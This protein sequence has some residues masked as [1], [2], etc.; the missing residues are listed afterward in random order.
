M[1]TRLAGIFV[2]VG[3]VAALA[4][5]GGPRPS[6][7]AD[8]AAVFSALQR[9]RALFGWPAAKNP[10][11]AQQLARRLAANYALYATSPGLSAAGPGFTPPGWHVIML[12]PPSANFSGTPPAKFAMKVLA[13]LTGLTGRKDKALL[14]AREVSVGVATLPRGERGAPSASYIYHG[15]TVCQFCTAD[16]LVV[17]LWYG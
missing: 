12:R 1:L 15:R 13:M 2:V 7:A 6:D 16:R 9:Q 4:G 10:G 14:R 8:R 3:V 17:F 5:C 11:Q